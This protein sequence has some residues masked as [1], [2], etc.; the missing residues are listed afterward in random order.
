MAATASEPVQDPGTPAMRMDTSVNTMGRHFQTLEGV[1]AEQTL[2]A[3]TSRP[4][5]LTNMTPVQEEVLGLLP[6]LA[7]LPEQRKNSDQPRDLLVRAKTG[8]GKT[9][10]F[11]VPAIEAR[12]KAIEAHGLQAVKD[13]GLVNDTG[14]RARAEKR[15]ARETVGTLIIS[16]TR[17]LATQIANEA[18][19]LSYH[20]D[21]FEV[22]LFTGG[23]SK[24]K[25]VREWMKGRRD[26]VVATTGRLRDLLSTEPSVVAALEHTNTVSFLFDCECFAQVYKAHSG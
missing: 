5:R 19:R 13:A 6:G 11:L 17:E 15:Y 12:I 23:T 18:L 14:L 21:G 10:A 24:M 2:Q 20:H 1:I 3:I 22:Q 16:P 8:T 26:I 25:Q 7:A 9:L 4:F